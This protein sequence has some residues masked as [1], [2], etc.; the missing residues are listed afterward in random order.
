MSDSKKSKSFHTIRKTKHESINSISR[1]RKFRPL[2]TLKKTITAV[3]TLFSVPEYTEDTKNEMRDSVMNEIADIENQLHNIKLDE[4]DIVSEHDIENPPISKHKS[5][6][7]GTRKITPKKLS[8]SVLRK[9][10]HMLVRTMLHHKLSE[11]PERM[12]KYLNIM[13]P[14]SGDCLGF[15]KEREMIKRYFDGFINMKYAKTP[16]KLLSSGANGFVNLITYQRD[17]YKSYAIIK[18]TIG[19]T[20]DNL[21]YEAMVGLKYINTLIPYFPCFLETYS[22][23][24][25]KSKATSLELGDAT[26]INNLNNL[27][28]IFETIDMSSF[29][30]YAN[31]CKSA[32][33]NSLLIEY[34]PQ[35]ISFHEL[36]KNILVNG[37]ASSKKH[38]SN[39]TFMTCLYQIYSVLSVLGDDYTHYDLHTE[40]VILYSVPNK[41][42]IK[43]VYH[44]PDG[45]EVSFFTRYIVKIIDYGR[46]HCPYSKQY[47]QEICKN[48]NKDCTS[49]ME[50]NNY[51][52]DCGADSG[53]HF[54]N[55]MITRDEFYISMLNPNKSHDLRCAKIVKNAV[56]K[57]MKKYLWKETEFLLN[58]VYYKDEYGTPPAQSVDGTAIIANVQNMDNALKKFLNSDKYKNYTNLV[59]NTNEIIGTMHVYLYYKPQKLMFGKSSSNIQMKPLMYIPN[60]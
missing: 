37:D 5:K 8:P 10:Q 36:I 50:P 15:A 9:T 57:N 33:K 56:I 55:T 45:S 14:S 49:H 17:N 20:S 1:T 38:F 54:F 39:S 22:A 4:K 40:N 26:T 24:K 42:Y 12:K 51:L 32:D 25:H 59:F 31:S 43:M 27:T 16:V 3:K 6:S 13:C 35:P 47:Y 23:L 29:E 53:H 60:E 19:V 2:K 52:P 21:F 58:N 48:L 7:P 34:V 44:Y 46:N 30:N 11:V 28:N 41:K 18:N